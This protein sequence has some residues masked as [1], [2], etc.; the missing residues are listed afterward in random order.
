MQN[1]NYLEYSIEIY[2]GE[3]DEKKIENFLNSR[4]NKRAI[5]KAILIDDELNTPSESDN[6]INK[7]PNKY[8]RKNIFHFL[9]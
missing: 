1:K 9:K 3:L 7:K 5:L 2:E 8:L 4:I 6:S